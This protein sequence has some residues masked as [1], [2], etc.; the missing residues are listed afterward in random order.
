MSN[1]FS[2]ILFGIHVCTM[3]PI[4]FTLAFNLIN[5]FTTIVHSEKSLK[6]GKGKYF[7]YFP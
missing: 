2:V 1:L 4:R 3:F 7:S 6:Y 5:I